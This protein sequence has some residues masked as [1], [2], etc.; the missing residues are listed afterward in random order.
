ML[1]FLTGVLWTIRFRSLP[2]RGRPP[3][4]RRPR[5][6]TARHF[7]G[8]SLFSGG[9]DSLIGA[10]DEL[11][12]RRMPLFVSHGGEEGVSGP[13]GKLF[14]ALKATG[15]GAEADA[16]APGDGVPPEPCP[17]YRRRELDPRPFL[18]FYRTRRIRRISLGRP[19]VLRV[20]ENGL[21][22]LNVP[23]DVTRLG[24]N[25]TRTTHPFYIH[26]WNE[27][28]PPI[29]RP[30]PAPKF[31]CHALALGGARTDHRWPDLSSPFAP[32]YSSPG[33]L[34]QEIPFHRQ[35]ADLGVKL[36]RL[37]LALLRTLVRSGRAAPKKARRLS[38]S[39]FFQLYLV[40]MHSVPL[41]HVRNCRVLA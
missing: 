28:L 39:C 19:F 22:S 35:L 14:K 2:E 4:R 36:R 17:G 9:L 26:R 15:L 10:I 11:H 30:C 33:P 23:L 37:A 21:I 29:G 3:L 25:S 13:Q 7:D 18:S 12:A 16:L 27:L 1:R 8:V 34:R 24:S 5:E 31:S 40:R 20:P 41:G 32:A 6:T 38:R